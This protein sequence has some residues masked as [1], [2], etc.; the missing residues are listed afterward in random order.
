MNKYLSLREL[1]GIASSPVRRLYGE[2]IEYCIQYA[3]RKL[4][5]TKKQAEEFINLACD[6]LDMVNAFNRNDNARK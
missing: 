6:Y 4:K 3:C 5:M 1:R 2:Y